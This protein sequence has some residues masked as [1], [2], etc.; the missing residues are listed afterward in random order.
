MTAASVASA[1]TPEACAPDAG[2]AHHV[3]RVIDGDTV[4]LD[5]GR[6]LRLM[7]AMAPRPNSLTVDVARWPPAQDATRALAALV[8]NRSVLLRYEGR[9]RDRY[10]RVLAQL[11]IAGSGDTRSRWVQRRL[12]AEGYARAYALPGNTAC[13]GP[14]VAAENEARLARRGLWEGDLYRV[15]KAAEVAALLRLV[16]RFVVVEGRV[17]GVTRTRRYTYINFGAD[18]RDDFTVSLRTPVVDRAEQGEARASALEGRTIRARGWIERRNGPMIELSGLDEIEIVDDE[19][20]VAT[21]TRTRD[22]APPNEKTP[23]R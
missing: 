16:G 10:G 19:T 4:E 8:L 6:E 15:H 14:L 20:A 5:N 7:G 12:V 11:V 23:R 18:W 13:L 17:A 21:E 1:N 3:V 22:T 2:E 9:R